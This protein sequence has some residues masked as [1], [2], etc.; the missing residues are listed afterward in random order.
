M[1]SNTGTSQ[2]SEC[3]DYLKASLEPLSSK[4]AAPDQLHVLVIV[5][6]LRNA[7]LFQPFEEELLRS[8]GLFL[9]LASCNCLELLLCLL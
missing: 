6:P 5:S 1:R 2:K 4:Q 7:E 9:F 3:D 8:S